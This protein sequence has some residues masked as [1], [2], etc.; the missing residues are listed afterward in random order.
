MT[1]RY[2]YI[3]SRGA[4]ASTWLFNLL[5]THPNI[6]TVHGTRSIPPYQSGTADQSAKEFFNRFPAYRDVRKTNAHIIGGIHGYYGLS[7]KLAVEKHGG[8]FLSII[9]D[10][11]KRIHSLFSHSFRNYIEN[12]N[13]LSNN[14]SIYDMIKNDY[15]DFRPDRVALN[16]DYQRHKIKS[17]LSTLKA[18]LKGETRISFPSV[19]T[20][21]GEKLLFTPVEQTFLD[22]CASIFNDDLTLM[23]ALNPNDI[24]KME[25]IV[26][27]Q[28]TCMKLMAKISS[29]TISFSESDIKN[30][31]G[32]FN[33]KIR[34]H[35][36][37]ASS[38]E[39][40]Y[41][42]WPIS[43]KF[44]YQTILKHLGGAN[45]VAEYKARFNYDLIPPLEHAFYVS[46][47]RI[48]QRS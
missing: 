29:E 5:N 36:K 38:A 44:I 2:F 40:V 39:D 7:A 3:S 47:G 10:P 4:S 20:I 22:L 28:A 15:L 34:S 9:R 48:E 12:S 27:N 6:L 19:Y 18:T 32:H 43:F 41:N 46:K 21:N 23:R 13:G 8:V 24:Y 37:A 31:S 45:I 33:T 16:K 1:P 35:A 25:D 11:I 42:T 26:S 30:I 17:T 14:A